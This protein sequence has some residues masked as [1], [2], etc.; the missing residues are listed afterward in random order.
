M[1]PYRIVSVK[2]GLCG[3]AVCGEY[4]ACVSQGWQIKT[5]NN[6]CPECLK[7]ESKR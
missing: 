1:N 2:C 7:K 3:K 5:M 6:R 4:K